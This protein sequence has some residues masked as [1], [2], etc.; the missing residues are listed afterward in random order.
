MTPYCPICPRRLACTQAAIC[1]VTHK[2]IT[3]P[4]IFDMKEFYAA[5]CESK[6]LDAPSLGADIKEWIESYKGGLMLQ[7]EIL[8]NPCN[9]QI[10]I[11]VLFGSSSV[12]DVPLNKIKDDAFEW[13]RDNP[14][15]RAQSEDSIRVRSPDQ[16]RI[17]YVGAAIHLGKAAV[18]TWGKRP[19]KQASNDNVPE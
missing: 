13:L 1:I 3:R 12:K 18:A 7:D 2:Q 9:Q 4:L 15:V 17:C 16:W 5:Y 19:P 6:G 10:D 8:L 14:M 11:E